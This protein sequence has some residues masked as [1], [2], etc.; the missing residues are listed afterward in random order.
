MK[1]YLFAISIAFIS[2]NNQRGEISSSSDIPSQ[3]VITDEWTVDGTGTNVYKSDHS[4]SGM[5]Y[6]IYTSGA[7]LVVINITLDSINVLKTKKEQ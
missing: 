5:H 3:N 7:G 6:R 1:K 2:C 4:I